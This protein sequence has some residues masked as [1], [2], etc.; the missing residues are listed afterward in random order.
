M[1]HCSDFR[2]QVKE[3]LSNPRQQPTIKQRLCSA[4][5]VLL[6]QGQLRNFLLVSRHLRCVYTLCALMTQERAQNDSV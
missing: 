5:T 4:T 3:P 1:T 6:A 2:E